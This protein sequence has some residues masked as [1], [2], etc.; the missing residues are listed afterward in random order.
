MN[1]A[2]RPHHRNI[3]CIIYPANPLVQGERTHINFQSHSSPP[4]CS[5]QRL[6]LVRSFFHSYFFHSFLVVFPS[7]TWHRD[8]RIG[9]RGLN[10]VGP[11]SCGGAFT[12]PHLYLLFVHLCFALFFFSFFRSYSILPKD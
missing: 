3:Y 4:S 10:A 5:K 11:A 7:E 6:L 12:F 1:G 8:Y 2:P 9:P